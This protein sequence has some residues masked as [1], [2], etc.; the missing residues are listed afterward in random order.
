MNAA[1]LTGLS[2]NMH[3]KQKNIYINVKMTCG[4][5]QGTLSM[6]GGGLEGGGIKLEKRTKTSL[7]EIAKRYN[8]KG[9]SLMD[10]TGLIKAIRSKYEELGRRRK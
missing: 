8:I 1:F 5:S 2:V 10:K 6:S 4:C 7:Y 9:R 3:F